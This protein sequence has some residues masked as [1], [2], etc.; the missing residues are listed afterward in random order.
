MKRWLIYLSLLISFL[1]TLFIGS[2]GFLVGTEAGLRFITAVAQ[3]FAPGTLKI[4]TVKGLLLNEI[5]FTGV[6][7]QYEDTAVQVASFQFVWDAEALLDGKLHVKKLH[8][9]AIEA[10]LPKSRQEEK[11]SAPLELPDIDLPIQIVL[12]DVQ[13]HQVTIRTAEAEP[14]IIDSIELRS[15]TKAKVWSLQH[16]KIKSPLFNAKLAGDVG[17]TTPHT[18]QLN[19]DW[20]A[21]LPE[22]TVVG[23]GELNGDMQKLILTHTVS[24]PLE[25]ELES[26]VE[27]VLGA[28]SMD[29]QLIW[30]EVYWPLNPTVA[31][32]YLV[33][34]QQGRVT[35]SGTLDNYRFDLNAK[36]SGKQIPAGQWTIIAQGNQQE[37]TIEKLRTELLKGVVKATG[38]V[39]WQPKLA[40]QLNLN[41]D[42]I[43]L[44]DFWNE[45]P[46]ELRL[47][48][49]V[50]AKLDGDDFQIN[51]LDVTL[52]QTATKLSLKGEGVVAGEKSRFKTATLTWQNVQWP[53]V[54][55]D[56]IVKTQTGRANLSGTLQNYRVDLETQLGSSAQIPAGHL[57]LKGQGNLQQFI[58]E[59]LHSTLL[60]GTVNATGQV[61]WEPKLAAQL[62]L[63]ADK[64]TIKDFWTDWPD[65]LRLNSQLKAKLD[66]DTFKISTLKVNI[67][68]TAAQLS[69]KGEGTL[70]D[71]G[72]RFKN[73]TLAWLNVQWPLVG[74]DSIVKSQRGR[75]NLSGTLQNYRVDL[76]TRLAGPQ[77]PAGLLTLKG[78]GNLQ[79]F[80]VKSLRTKILK[81][82]VNAT[83]QVS[84]VPKLAAQLNLKAD[85]ITIKDFW[86]DWPDNLRL[87]SQLK[88]K[89]DGD[90]FKI[91]TLKVNI[92]QTAAQL[93]LKGEGTLAD[94]GPRFK[95]ATLAWLN[96]QWPLVGNDSIVKSQRGRANLSGTLQNYRVDLETRLA[97][98]QIPAGL[99]TLK[100]QGNLQQFTV[101]SLRTKILK[102]TVN[103]TGQVSWVPKLAAQLNLKADKITIKDFW[104]DWPDN[105]RLN[106]QLKAKLDGDTFK[107]S[108]L[109]VNI[110]QTAAQLSLKGEGTLADDGPRF[111]NATL[112]WL[113]V[114]WPLVGND[115]IVKSQ[116]GRANLSG[117]LQNYRVDLETRLAGPQIPAGLL[118]LKGQGNL[119]QFTVKSLRTKILKGTV[120]ATGQVS[121]VPKLAAQLNLKA[122]K[123][124]IKDFWTDWP[125]NL[126]L[127]SQLKAKLDGDTFKISTLKVN[128]PQTAAQLSLKG[129]GTLAGENTRFN[130]TLAWQGLQWPLVGKDALVS[131]QKGKLNAKGTAQAYKLRL[132]ADIQG[133]DIPQGRWQ[134]VGN[135]DLSSMQLKS[136][137][138]KILQGTLDLTGKVRWQPDVSW[139]VALKGKNINP[140]RQWTDWPGKL[141]LNIQSQGR[142]KNG[143]LETQLKI[144]QVRGRLRDYP[145]QLKAEQIAV[146]IPPEP[147]LKTGKTRRSQNSGIGE[148]SIKHLEIQ[149]GSNRLTANGKLGQRSKL[150]WAINAPDLK[151]LLPDGQGSLIGKGHLSGP[152][153]LPYITAQLK[154][155]SLVF[156]DNSLKALTADIDVNLLSNKD[157]RLEVIATELSLG[158]TKID[159][160]RLY[161][162]G[163]VSNH[164]LFAS[165]IT[166]A[167]RF[168][169]QLRGRFKQ[170]RWQ[171]RLQKLTA[172]TDSVG[173]WQLQAPAALSLSATEAKLARSCLQNTQAAKLCTQLH[174]QK[175]ADSNL[176]VWL[177][178][179][180]LNLVYPFLPED[181]DLTGT[182]EGRVAA[183]L[184]PDG[185]IDSD[186]SINLSPGAFRTHFSEEYIEELPHKGGYLKLTVTKK[187]GLVA[188]LELNLLKQSG[189]QG[190]FNMPRFTH[191]P[192]SGEQPIQGHLKATFAD[193]GILPAF[194]PQAENTQGRVNLNVR[195]G[196]T[197][198]APNVQG[199]IQVQKAAADLPDFGLELRDLT[200]DIVSKG[201]D[202][203]Q[204]QARVNSGEG[205]LKIN[206][207]ANSIFATEERIVNLNIAGTDFQVV[208]MPEVWALASPN[209]NIQITPTG[210]DVTGK[211]TIPKA[212]ITPLKAASG[213]VPISEDVVYVNSEKTE[214]PKEEQKLS[215]T[216]AISS[217]V[218]IILGDDVSLEAAGFK[219]RFG[220]KLVASNQPGKV[221]VGNGELYIL[222]GSYKA[223]GQNLKIDRGRVFFSG[224]PI[225]NPGLDIKAYRRIKRSAYDNVIAGVH[226]QGTAQDPKLT[227]YSKPALDQS[228][229]LSYIVLGKP[230]SEATQGEG[231]LLLNAA[232]SLP[233]KQGD[234]LVNKIGQKF[235]LDEA[236][237][238]TDDGLKKAALVLGKYLTP[239]LYISYG[240]GLFDGSSV[241][242]MRY[243]LM[244]NLTIETETGS[245]S[246]VDLRYTLER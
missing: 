3:Q 78:Q 4:D 169:L 80:T 36:V 12:D 215:E 128:I 19:L 63:K 93:S 148:I 239:G 221:T 171:G 58:I 210:I 114:Q 79:Q 23:Q 75:A 223:Y 233:F 43:T 22:F 106:S 29:T 189:L 170:P 100:G 151:T 152:V 243:E 231:N 191:L 212:K 143:A 49:Q 204:M 70:A 133:K 61:S 229:T 5:N 82:T 101:K 86:T 46:D 120:N 8:I 10:D 201:H 118:T 92:P 224:G 32:D 72:P 119:Q 157:L 97:G 21:K 222:D 142:L 99:L 181:S 244:D 214:A 138:G 166:P 11:D 73:A 163:R 193:L 6:S 91:S 184:R 125:D 24:K 112:A 51:Q 42:E 172:S 179:L 83:G 39:S 25:V 105:L 45:W 202:T 161:G 140:G 135:G 183:T 13:I 203:L 136:L 47:D 177:K 123:I 139:Q 159:R 20:S 225:E 18:V 198:A 48:G 185:A 216:M 30:Q 192:P 242:R 155:N 186:V 232:A 95:N 2:L 59:S 74:N 113:N 130:S 153:Y 44:K 127:N 195:L 174:W 154:G 162:Q 64:I 37:L 190:T 228:N 54:G 107:I 109:K 103:A 110:P 68:Q 26:T 246:G 188:G 62:N 94:D 53:L 71:D 115:S 38:K 52:P 235:G 134:A 168:S 149:S 199:R 102:G 150:D 31:K 14:L 116:R 160:F 41:V 76:E 213:A 50:V 34:S 67:P 226:I 81:G 227:L 218:E 65:N 90:T 88:A 144:K 57:A 16:F 141:A 96:V 122:D 175:T 176:Q 145:F 240:I 180:P 15:N 173:Y 137:H 245:Q 104:T 126:R 124:T 77:I 131:S 207:K 87:N 241:L 234:N 236:G 194:V 230:A 1:L 217:K 237:I 196:G 69:L 33:H 132:N 98:P 205:Q 220:G 55:N 164:T 121:W 17:L 147:P 197:L 187:K 56:S 219:S 84:W 111:K 208:N 156:Q 178:S 89:L 28:F 129:D 40:A 211:V 85:K 182:V 66:G 9:K 27:D 158:T 167:D 146:E 200:M 238:S 165:L 108:T 209:L 7:Y 117:T 206:G 60:E 35:L